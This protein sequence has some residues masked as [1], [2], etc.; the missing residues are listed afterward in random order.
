M[1]GELFR[2]GQH[3]DHVQIID[4]TKIYNNRN[5]SVKE[6]KSLTKEV[7]GVGCWVQL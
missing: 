1:E 5:N 7:L 4:G 6:F 3:V 2:M